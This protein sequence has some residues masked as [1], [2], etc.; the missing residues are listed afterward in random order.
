MKKITLT[1][2]ATLFA[3]TSSFAQASLEGSAT[4][5]QSVESRDACSTTFAEGDLTLANAVTDHGP[6]SVAND[7]IV[8]AESSLSLETLNILLLP[9]AGDSADVSALTAIVHE[10]NGT[11][12]GAV[13]ATT[14]LTI[15]GMTDHPETFANFTQTYFDLTL[16]TPVLLEN[17]DA[18]AKTF[19]VEISVTSA[20]AQHIYWTGYVW[21]D[22]MA[23]Q[24]NYQSQDAGVTFA[25]IDNANAPGEQYDSEWTYSGDCVSLLGVDSAALAQVSVYPNPASDVLNIKVPSSVELNGVV[26]YD[27][28]GKAANV[29]LSNGQINVASLSRGMYILNVSTSAGTLTE[30]VII[31]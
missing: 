1:L 6:F 26:L 4:G 24:V 9:L 8:D 3:L 19:W 10:D 25:P 12:P 30:K 21:D 13:V 2:A 20:S 11:G 28:L 17:E 16:D 22:T 7:L 23:T 5:G 31:E 18:E 14:T 15:D 29:T 27:V